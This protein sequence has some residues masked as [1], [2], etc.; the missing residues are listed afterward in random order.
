MRRNPEKGLAHDDECRD[1]EERIGGKIM[2]IDPIVIHDSMNKWVKGK[3]EP[4]DKMR[5][6][7]NPLVRL[8]VRD[9]LSCH[10]KTV[11][12]FLG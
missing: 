5:K 12:D 2:K 4:A 1:I 11:A 9:D 8:R 3:P 6:K 10:R 7:N